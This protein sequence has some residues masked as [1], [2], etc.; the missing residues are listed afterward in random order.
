MLKRS[1]YMNAVITVVGHDKVGI[2]ARVSTLLYEKN[3]NILD[4]S[5]TIMQ[6]NF[7]MVMLVDVSASTVSFAEISSA[8]TQLGKDMELNIGIQREEI[9]DAMHTI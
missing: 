4:L 5:Q 2:I 1:R 3:I 6:G 9:F 7:T 8:L